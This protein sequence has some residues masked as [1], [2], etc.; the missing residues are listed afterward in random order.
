MSSVHPIF[1]VAPVSE[2]ALKA[3]QLSILGCVGPV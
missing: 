1:E 3:T 2:R